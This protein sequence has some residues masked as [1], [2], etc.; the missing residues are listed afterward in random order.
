MMMM[1]IQGKWSLFVQN[2]I[3]FYVLKNFTSTVV[4]NHTKSMWADKDKS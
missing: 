2:I 1:I 4:S 3:T